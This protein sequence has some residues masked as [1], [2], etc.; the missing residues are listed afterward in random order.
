MARGRMVSS[1]ICNSSKMAALS[2][3]GAR[4]LFLYLLV[5]ADNLG[6]LRGEPVQVKG[7]AFARHPASLRQVSQWLLEL[8]NVGLIRWYIHQGQRFISIERWEEHQDLSKYGRV[9]KLPDPADSQD[10]FGEN[11]RGSPIPRQEVEVE[12]ESEVEV[13]GEV[14]IEGGEH[15]KPGSPPDFVL[16]PTNRQ[17]ETF[18]I[19]ETDLLPLK[20]LYPGVDIEQEFRN[21]RG[22][23]E[24]NPKRRK[25]HDGMSRFIHAWLAKAQN[26]AKVPAPSGRKS[27]G[28]SVAEMLAIGDRMREAERAKG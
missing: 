7:E 9:S 27:R 15:K 4:L 24:G 14:E 22:W 16:L 6:R 12:V 3:D 28:L 2:C 11:R 10:V 17:G 8:A 21:M 13:K 19:I 5:S 18:P 20:D 1:S 23:L 26:S 25:T